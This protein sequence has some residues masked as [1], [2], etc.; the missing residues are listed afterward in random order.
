M[1][2]MNEDALKQRAKD[3]GALNGID[4]ALVSLQPSGDPTEARIELHFHNKHQ[5]AIIRAD[6]PKAFFITGGHRIRAG[7]AEG[8]VRVVDVD[9][10]PPPNSPKAVILTVKPIGDYSTYTLAIDMTAVSNIDPVFS[11]VEFKFRPGCFNVNCA[12]RE[13][14]PMPPPA[15]DIDYLA[16]DYESFR[17]TMIAAM[18]ERVP[19]WRM[20]SEA[21]LDTVL[22]E[23]W[24]V[25]ADELSDQ[26]DRVMNEAYLGTARK[27]VSL[28]RHARLMDYHI[29]QGNQASTWLALHLSADGP[30]AQKLT[31]GFKVWAGGNE[32]NDSSVVFMTRSEQELHYI[33]NDI[34]LFTWSDTKPSLAAGSTTADLKLTGK[35]QDAES[36]QK[37]IQEGTVRHL[38]IEEHLNP[39]T[40]HP[41]GRDPAKRQ[42]L[43]LIKGDGN[44]GATVVKDPLKEKWLVRIHWQEEL[45]T[46]YCFVVDCNSPAQ[47][48]LFH[49]NLVEVYHGR[50][51]SAVFKR[52]GQAAAGEFEF[53]ET[54][55]WGTICKLPRAAGP[56]AY[57]ATP[58]DGE[59]H[60][61]S[62][63]NVTVDR[64]GAPASGKWTEEINLIRTDENENADTYMVETDEEGYSLMR[65]KHGANGKGLGDASVSCTYQVGRGPDGNIGRDK[66]SFY[67][68]G[69]DIIVADKTIAIADRVETCWNPFD[70]T[71]GRA[72]EPREEIIRRVPEAYRARQLRAVTLPDYEARAEQLE[73]VSMA[74]ARYAWTGAWRTVRIAF[75]PSSE[76]ALADNIPADLARHLESV[77]LIGED[78]EIRKPRMVP[79]DIS[80][81]LCIEPEYWPADI[82]F[83]L[84]Q[85]F[86]EGYTPD[87]RKGFFH[88]DLWTFG[89][90]LHASEIA[91]R[92]QAVVGVDHI[93][94]LTMRRRNEVKARLAVIE[95]RANE[96]IQVKSDADHVED[97]MMTFF[98]EGGRA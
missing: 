49:G 51:A 31:A 74:A 1:V 8:Q 78:L 21:D 54:D 83:I 20:T 85:E 13:T 67:D 92:V 35:K 36:V 18:M 80:A 28:A 82:M 25:A 4:L 17:H 72:P 37:L 14:G 55:H 40:C 47:V 87:G 22:L 98:L 3:L 50:P 76:A 32:L 10:N 29:H 86:S 73:D 41:A 63:L 15:A 58:P 19:G 71:N 70:V 2:I 69:H 38:V 95:L 59:V 57:T 48:S 24:S 39:D 93:V 26:Q 77:R 81:T 44:R 90:A 60:P 89:Q 62:T 65:F 88:P 12:E 52:P 64:P 33:L 9:A 75:D 34:E 84:E 27:R 56:L 66:L 96:I 42:L 61:K 46:N 45:K 43:T 23:L 79:L 68:H 30:A 94:N 6:G 5:L 53:E 16:K 97:G 91:G 11:E 7:K